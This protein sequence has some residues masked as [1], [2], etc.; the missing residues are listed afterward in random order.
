MMCATG[1]VESVCNDVGMM[2]A[3]LKAEKL[4]FGASRAFFSFREESEHSHRIE[5]VSLT[6]YSW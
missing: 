1:A 4:K 2:F 5:R 6:G 3:Q